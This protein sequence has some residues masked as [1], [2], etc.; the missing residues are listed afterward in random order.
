MSIWS[1]TYQQSVFKRYHSDKHF[2]EFLPTRWRQKSTRIDME[3]HDVT[4]TLCIWHVSSRSGEAG[5]KLLRLL[6]CL[7]TLWDCCESVTTTRTLWRGR[8]RAV[9]RS[10]TRCPTS[11]PCWCRSAAAVSSP[12]SPS[13]SSRSHPTSKSTWADTHARSTQMRPIAI[14]VGCG[15]VCVCLC[16]FVGHK[17]RRTDQ[18]AVWCMDSGGPKELCTRM[19]VRIPHWKREGGIRTI[20]GHLLPIVKYRIF[21]PT[22]N[23]FGMW[24][25]RCGLSLSVLQQIVYCYAS[26]AN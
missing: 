15:V 6:T 17:N 23:L 21:R 4:V 7:L 22:P 18:C 11:T 1:L 25:R 16:V 5:C 14:D 20:R 3:Q 19:E 8:A 10:S 12:A 9:W 26:I 24:H 2:S 13:P